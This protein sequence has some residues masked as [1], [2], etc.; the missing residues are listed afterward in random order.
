M[1][2]QRTQIL[3]ALRVTY[4]AVETNHANFT[5]L[6]PHIERL[7]SLIDHLPPA[8]ATAEQKRAR[9]AER[10]LL[11]RVKRLLQYGPERNNEEHGSGSA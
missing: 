6:R 1:A 2:D 10:V 4:Q 11:H 5:H 9:I 7:A 8:T 3:D